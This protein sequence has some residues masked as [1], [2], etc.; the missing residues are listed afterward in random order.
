MILYFTSI[1]NISYVFFFFT[2]RRNIQA[3]TDKLTQEKNINKDK[4]RKIHYI[5]ISLYISAPHYAM[6]SY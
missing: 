1:I 3:Y 6:Y 5:D 2:L 4:N